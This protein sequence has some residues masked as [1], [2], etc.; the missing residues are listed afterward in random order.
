MSIETNTP[1]KPEGASFFNMTEEQVQKV[2]KRMQP[3]KWSYVG[4]LKKGQCGKELS[5]MDKDALERRGVTYTE[6]ATK[7]DELALIIFNDNSLKETSWDVYENDDWEFNYLSYRG[8]QG[9]PFSFRKDY[10]CSSGEGSWEVTATKKKTGEKLFF[11][12][13][14][15]HLI[16]KHG[17]FE[18]GPYRLD[19]D[20]ACDFFGLGNKT[21]NKKV[22]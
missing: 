13:L 18:D 20:K 12:G 8:H 14:H 11:A 2:N 1:I 19:P 16:K 9:C 10:E 6:I 4:F 5:Q 22:I 17:V 3:N 21:S 15:S 7:L